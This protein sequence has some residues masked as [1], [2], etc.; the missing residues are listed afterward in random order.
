MM[1]LFFSFLAS[2]TLLGQKV[3]H[4]VVQETDKECWGHGD[5]LVF[6]Q[7]IPYIVDI[8]QYSGLGNGI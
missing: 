5:Y 1:C 3:C 6:H 2:F 8:L 4:V 7:K